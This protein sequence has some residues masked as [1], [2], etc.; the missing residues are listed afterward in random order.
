MNDFSQLMSALKRTPYHQWMA[1]EGLPVVVGHGV[2]DVRE[3]PL[4]PW[5]RT[6]GKGSFIHLYGMEGSSGM[7]V[8]EIPPGGALHP[9]RHM[10]EEVIVI[11]E[12]N[13]ATEVWQE[14]GKKHIFEWSRWSL[15]APPLN[16]WHRLVNGGREPVKFFAVTTAPI[17]MDLYRNDEFIFN[18]PFV[19]HERFAGEEGY[20]SGPGKRYEIR[21]VATWDTNF[22]ADVSSAAI[23]TCEEKGVG[24]LIT[25]FEIAGNS[26][27]GHLS[28]WPAGLYHKAHYHGPGSVLFGLQSNGYVL[29]WSKDLGTRPYESGNGGEVVEM[30]WKD[31]SLYCPPGGW[32]HQHFNVGS[33]PAR[34]LAIRFGGRVHPTG[35]ATA[36]KRHDE[37]VLMSIKN[38]GTLLEYEDEDPEIRRRFEAG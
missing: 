31:G 26:L 28:Q 12:G 8:G 23:D 11:L 2:E 13:G 33:A 14:G 38:G 10:Y 25:C 1:Q 17:V 9:E 5:R 29:L 7:Y 22:I 34:Q 20:F 32:F 36:A 6:G 30:S 19:F 16:S 18:S 24:A 21:N 15:F 35:F 4:S 37:G 3:L 27:V